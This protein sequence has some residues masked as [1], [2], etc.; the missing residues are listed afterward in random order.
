MFLRQLQHRCIASEILPE[1]RPDDWFE[2]WPRKQPEPRELPVVS[3]LARGALS[4]LAPGAELDGL[5]KPLAV[6]TAG[7]LDRL[8]AGVELAGRFE[9]AD[10]DAAG[11]RAP[12]Q[13]TAAEYGDIT[14]TYSDIRLGRSDLQI[15][16][17][18]AAD[19]ESYKAGVMSDIADVMQTRNG[20][21]LISQLADNEQRDD[22]GRP[23]R[24]TTTI[25][26]NVD[27][28]LK[29]V[30][31]NAVT[32]GW[33]GQGVN[34]PADGAAGIGS[35]AEVEINPTEIV[36]KYGRRYRSDVALAHELKHAYDFSR[37]TQDRAKVDPLDEAIAAAARFD[38]A[39]AFE[40]AM[41]PSPAVRH[42]VQRQVY[43]SEHQAAG[44]GLYADA[45]L[46]ENAYRRERRQITPGS[47]RRG[48]ASMKR[49]EVYSGRP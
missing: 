24:R 39:G 34:T 12:N 4:V 46:T 3:Q 25:M 1:S 17:L 23:T 35:N 2:P 10:D 5:L 31:D 29:P 42:D 44:L 14:K 19:A 16:G 8:R 21:S 7:V 48:D 40:K 45:P 30:N 41:R 43:R 9:I 38:V 47:R 33:G 27:D 49:R 6:D 22:C 18:D 37:G 20:R 13:V 28:E 15:D 36:T 26:P 32:T 11:E